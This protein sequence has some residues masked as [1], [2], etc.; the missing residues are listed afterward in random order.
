MRC[1][2]QRDK[3]APLRAARQRHAM[4]R[5]VYDAAADAAAPI[6]CYYLRYMP[7]LRHAIRDML[8]R[9]CAAADVTRR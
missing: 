2:L 3:G 4:L 5:L 7:D 1:Y 9:Y 6:R 8:P